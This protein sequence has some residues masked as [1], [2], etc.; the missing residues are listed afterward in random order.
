M[1]AAR[2]TAAARVETISSRENRWLKMFRTALAR[3]RPTDEGLIGVEGPRLVEEA[4]RAQLELVALLASPAGEQHLVRWLGRLGPGVRLLR[5][6]ERLFATVTSTKAPQGIAALV[7][8]RPCGF[9][10]LLRGDVP[11][12]V[13]LAGVQDPGNVGTIIR[14]AEALGA[15]GV[16]TARL[17]E[18]SSANPL[19]PK[20]LRASAGSAL[21]MPVLAGIS[22]PTLLVQLRISGVRVYAASA[23]SGVPPAEL[24]FH[25]PAALLIGNEGA[26]LP[27]EA[28]RSADALARIPLTGSPAARSAVDS[29]NAAVAAAILL[30]EAARQRRQTS[31]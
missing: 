3:G 23:A 11:L 30:Y 12:V 22:F 2:Q 1:Q 9:E 15:T 6:T 19:A 26:G 27:P 28:E 16:V 13:V 24:D 20:A 21:R 7:R 5:T 10:D 18:Q 14:T 4:I 29:L 31:G 17:G 8:P 25:V